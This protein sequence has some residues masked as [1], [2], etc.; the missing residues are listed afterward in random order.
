VQTVLKA[1]LNAQPARGA[2]VL[3]RRD[4]NDVADVRIHRCTMFAV[5]VVQAR[6]TIGPGW[7]GGGVG[8][9]ARERRHAVRLPR[10]AATARKRLLAAAMVLRLQAGVRL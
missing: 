10:D 5:V 9:R 6:A 4:R 7:D 1:T 3:R 2:V 8:G